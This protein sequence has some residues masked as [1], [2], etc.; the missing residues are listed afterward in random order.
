MIYIFTGNGKGKTSASLGVALRALGVMKKV[1]IIQFLKSGNSSEFKT[2]K[3]YK[4][5][6][7]VFAYSAGFYKILGD[8]KPKSV[9]KKEAQKA[10]D[11]TKMIL[12][13]NKYDVIILDELNIAIYYGLVDINEVINLLNS[14]DSNK[15]EIVITGRNAHSKLKKIADLIT[16]M[17]EVKHY[18]SK[19]IKA[20]KGIDY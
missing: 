2:I 6:I 7:D 20:R 1:A 10:L 9:H 12:S 4:L 5:P 8:K 17:K 14:V 19:D 16:E 3:K 11:K 15:V 13:K 18:F